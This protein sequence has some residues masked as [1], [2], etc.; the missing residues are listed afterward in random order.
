MRV[1]RIS[2]R[3]ADGEHLFPGYRDLVRRPF[4]VAWPNVPFQKGA[5]IDWG[6][7]P[8]RLLRAAAAGRAVPV[9]G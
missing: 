8:R 4:S 3:A 7:A 5:W 6:D 9:H 2:R 1:G